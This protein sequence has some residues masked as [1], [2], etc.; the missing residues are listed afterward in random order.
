MSSGLTTPGIRDRLLS[1]TRRFV[2]AASNV[3]GVLRIGLIG[4][5]ATLKANPKDIDLLITVSD[6][7]DL[8]PLAL[9][10]R[11][12][13]GRLQAFNS[14][15]DVFLADEHGHYLGRTCQWR[16]CR[17][18]Q[19][20]SCDA[21]HCG[22][23]QYLHDDLGTIRLDPALIATPPA[24]LWPTIERRGQ[25]PADVEQFLAALD[26]PPNMACSRPWQV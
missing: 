11:R 13:Q 9:C 7:A 24:Q 19:R 2:Q 6:D 1:E 20:A 25:L 10:A 12:L 23:R 5:V 26:T 18:G 15:A 22:R 4:S 8:A 14:G 17:P 3:P 21:Q 16:E